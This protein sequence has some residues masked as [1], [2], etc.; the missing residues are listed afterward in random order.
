MKRRKSSA[1]KIGS[2]TIGGSHPVAVQSMTNTDTADVESS[3]EQV[4][5][6]AEAG[7]ELV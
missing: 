1:V 6:L 4:R 3:V 7:S 2:V 5:E